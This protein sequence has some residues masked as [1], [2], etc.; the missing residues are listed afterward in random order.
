ML[1]RKLFGVWELFGLLEKVLG[2][3]E[4]RTALDADGKGYWKRRM[5]VCQFL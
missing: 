3:P 4:P 5:E 2:A 1:Y